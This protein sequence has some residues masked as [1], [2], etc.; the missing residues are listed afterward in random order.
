MAAFDVKAALER[1]LA[2][3]SNA[4]DVE[5]LR[6]EL[7]SGVLALGERSVAAEIISQSIVI[8]GDNVHFELSEE[9]AKLLFSKLQMSSEDFSILLERLEELKKLIKVVKTTE[10]LQNT[11]LELSDKGILL[12]SSNS[13]Q[14][15]TTSTFFNH[16]DDE[17]PALTQL[18]GHQD[19]LAELVAYFHRTYT[20][21]RGQIV[22]ITGQYGY[23]TKAL[24]RAFFDA[25]PRKKAKKAVIRFWQGEQEHSTE[26]DSR[27]SSKLSARKSAFDAAPEFLRQ[28]D[29]SQFRALLAQLEEYVNWERLPANEIQ[30]ASV[31]RS[32]AAYG[33]PLILL[34]EDFEHA[35]ILWRD[36]IT[37]LAAEL[38]K[39]LPIILV[40]TMH[41]GR[42]LLFMEDDQKG[43]TANFILELFRSNQ[44]SIFHLGRILK[45]DIASYIEAS[46]RE[47]V[48]KVFE[49]TGG[50]PLLVQDFWE[51]AKRRQ[52]VIQLDDGKWGFSK[53]S[54]WKGWGTGRDYINEILDELYE[55]EDPPS[56]PKETMLKF[57]QLASMEGPI[58][59]IEAIANVFDIATEEFEYALSY[60][61]DGEDEEGYDQPG[62][63]IDIPPLMLGNHS[64]FVRKT[65]DRYRFQP[66]IVWHSLGEYNTLTAEDIITL[67]E[68][69]R[70]VYWPYVGPV[71][72]NLVKLYYLAGDKDRAKEFLK[73]VDPP[74]PLSS[75]K[76]EIEIL[77][78]D[79]SSFFTKSRLVHLITKLREPI[80]FT[81]EPKSLE[82]FFKILI[83]VARDLGNKP[84]EAMGFLYL[85]DVYL[86]TSRF[87]LA[88]EKY[89]QSCDIS[90][91]IDDRFGIAVAFVNLGKVSLSI[92]EAVK[93][94]EYFNQ[95][96][97]IIKELGNQD[98]LAVTLNNIGAAYNILSQFTKALDYYNQ[99]LSISEKS[100]NRKEMAVTLTNIGNFFGNLSQPD[101]ALEYYNQA[102]LLIEEAGD[103]TA[104]GNILCSFGLTF[105]KI[106]QKE[107]AL[108]Y[109]NMAL[110]TLEKIGDRVGLANTL[111][112]IG[113]VYNEYGKPEKALEYFNQALSIREVVGD[114]AGLANSFS[115]V[116][117]A[118]LKIGQPDKALEYYNQALNIIQDIGNQYRLATIIQNIGD[119]HLT[120]GQPEIA[121]E[122]FKQALQITVELDDR[123]SESI[124]RWYIADFYRKEGDLMRAIEEYQRVVAFGNALQA[125]H[126]EQAKQELTQ[127]EQEF[128]QKGN[129]SR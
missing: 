3:G 121:L 23:G 70:R 71:V 33:T 49:L 50:I 1:L 51:E 99:A 58:F 27:W 36:I 37:Y 113:G 81:R 4:A 42:N 38:V 61:I 16:Q 91:E 64:E 21:N 97:P 89:Q 12:E 117:G 76:T 5:L 120:I 19:K 95:A 46:N 15:L 56:L 43:P 32:M 54:E 126:I 44:A 88:L 17:L 39:D 93:A 29:L 11:I 107:K 48:D 53:Y 127:L 31:L 123:Y 72:N 110:A 8:T 86:E 24:G 84:Y 34:L 55:L 114:R 124:A 96:I 82:P 116:G 98:E 57:L 2:D 119:L 62:L 92:G 74:D 101:K 109:F 68:S 111:N 28:G 103:R 80:Y 41:T 106:G 75:L 115:N 108:E 45:E 66:L 73:Y 94:L 79:P 78:A 125:P 9:A 69:I 26:H 87:D 129:Q 102:L 77:L 13:H 118:Y 14:A 47:A 83:D 40:I 65:I 10:G 25:V 105:L 112:G 52:Q 20:E 63:V 67:A 35:P 122:R 60:L 85:G 100:G 59:S 30:A 18:I 22:V 128:A 7:A 104:Q 90:I 6:E